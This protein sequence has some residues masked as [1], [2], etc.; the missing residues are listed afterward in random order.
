MALHLNLYHEI[1]RM[2][3]RERRNPF[4]IAMLAGLLIVIGMTGWYFRRYAAVSGVQNQARGLRGTWSAL[5]P[6]LKKAE[7]SK[8]DL[9]A[10]QKAQK[11]LVDYLRGR[12]YWGP[13]L[14]TV[15]E[16]TPLNVQ[17]TSLT[18]ELVEKDG[19]K[20]VTLNFKGIAAGAQ[21]RTAAEGFRKALQEKFSLAYGGAVALFDANSL[22]DGAETVTLNGQTLGTAT[23]RISVKFAAA[24]PTPTPAPRP[25]SKKASR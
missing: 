20:N 19:A 22:E 21:P 6:E 1:H 5:E 18:G 13:V 8:E 9:L 24:A 10:R 14:G 15:A 11:T 4:K 7:T 3:E 2:A 16:V 17:L 12:F 25:E 23:F